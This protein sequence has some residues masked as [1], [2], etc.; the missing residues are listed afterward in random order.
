[1][2]DLTFRIVGQA[3]QGMQT[4]SHT[5]GKLLSRAGYHVFVNQ[6]IMSRIRGGHNFSQIRISASPKN[7]PS[8]MVAL[9]I[10]LDPELIQPHLASLMPDAVVVYDAEPGTDPASNVNRFPI[11]MTRIARTVGKNPIMTNAV[12]LGATMFLTGYPLEGL[13]A[14]LRETFQGKPDEVIKANLACAQAGYDH[15]LKTFKQTCPCRIEMP[16]DSS[17]ADCADYTDYESAKSADRCPRLFL[18]GS[19]AIALGAM[20]AG[21]KF[22]SGYPMSPSTPIMEFIAARAQE[23]GIVVEQSEDE[24]A[25]I[26]MALGASYAG[27]RAMTATSGGGFAL[28]IESLGL[29]GM[30]ETPIVIALCQRP[31][32]ATGFPTRTE[33]ADLLFSLYAGQD[34]FPRFIFAPGSPEQAFYLTARAFELADKYQVPAIVLSDQLLCDS[35]STVEDFDLT[36]LSATEPLASAPGADRPA[37]IYRR[38]ILTSHVSP[39]LRP[40]TKNQ[41]V[42][43]AGHEHNEAGYIDE[44]AVTRVQMMEKRLVKLDLMREQMTGLTCFPEEPDETIIA[45]FGST[46]GAVSEAVA[47]LRQQQRRVSML[48]LS[49]LAPFPRELVNSA[50]SRS[51]RLFTVENNATA[52][53]A[54]LIHAETRIDIEDSVLKYDGRPFTAREIVRELEAKL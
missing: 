48:H 28:M 40:G 20:A 39:R 15:A 45:C 50:A 43:A 19:E 24:I 11:P 14:N 2:F 1:M 25:G 9:L 32:P 10:A 3:G 38:Y 49:S 17:S 41:V 54:H 6:D 53:L 46:L 37:Y 52:Q 34:E 51:R 29:A 33:Q 18:T 47:L 13:L 26:S 31:G 16:L 42:V 22:Y 30:S 8:D 36:R 44:S 23:F 7:C 4:I 35:Y 27:A 5:L 21:L 12:A